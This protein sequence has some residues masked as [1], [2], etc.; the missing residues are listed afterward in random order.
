LG[1]AA[2]SFETALKR[3]PKNIKARIHLAEVYS[4]AGQNERA[5]REIATTIDL[6]GNKNLFKKVLRDLTTDGKSR[7]LQVNR[8]VIFPLMREVLMKKSKSLKGWAEKL[9]MQ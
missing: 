9:P 5:E 7:N 1:R 3:N 2:V 8:E 4:A 6:I